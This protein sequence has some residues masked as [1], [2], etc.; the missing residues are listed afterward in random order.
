MNINLDIDLFRNPVYQ[1]GPANLVA[2]VVAIDYCR[3]LNIDAIPEFMKAVKD[4]RADVYDVV[5]R[6]Y[7][8][9]VN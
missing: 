9:H 8:Q 6:D 1:A 5:A 3:H 4:W 2:N 7:P